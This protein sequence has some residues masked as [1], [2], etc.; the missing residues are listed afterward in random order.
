M[1]DLGDPKLSNLFDI[2]VR[3]DEILSGGQRLYSAA[4]LEKRQ[5]GAGV[6]AEGIQDYVN[7]FRECRSVQAEVSV[8][9]DVFSSS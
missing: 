3:G 2:F 7:A 4:E 1:P 6:D 5:K 8:R 9:L